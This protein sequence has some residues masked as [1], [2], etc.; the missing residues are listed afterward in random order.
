RRVWPLGMTT[1]LGVDAG[2]AAAYFRDREGAV[3][4]VDLDDGAT[5]RLPDL[6]GSTAVAQL[7]TPIR[8]TDEAANAVLT[9]R[10]NAERVLPTAAAQLADPAVAAAVRCRQIVEG[11][12]PTVRRDLRWFRE[13]LRDFPH[14]DPQPLLSGARAWLESPAAADTLGEGEGVLDRLLAEGDFADAFRSER[15]MAW[16]FDAAIRRL[17]DALPDDASDEA[18]GR[19][20]AAVADRPSQRIA[21]RT[22]QLYAEACAADAARSGSASPRPGDQRLTDAYR[23][24]RAEFP[25]E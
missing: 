20:A 15:A 5:R 19:V 24:A 11:A 18:F 4:R 12:E 14:H 1:L 8:L 17:A 6:D 9:T 16:A 2:A 3:H 21:A 22:A 25:A 23:R 10:A 13:R 7:A